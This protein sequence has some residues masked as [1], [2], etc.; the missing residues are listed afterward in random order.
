MEIQGRWVKILPKTFADKKNVEYLQ[1]IIFLFY[2]VPDFKAPMKV[3]FRDLP[4][5]VKIEIIESEITKIGYYVIKV[6]QTVSRK[7]SRVLPFFLLHLPRH[8]NSKNILQQKSLFKIRIELENYMAPRKVAQCWNFQR[9]FHAS[10]QCFMEPQ[11]VACS[12]A[13]KSPVCPRKNLE[14]SETETT[15]QKPP[16]LG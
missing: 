10:A 13:H 12:A 7:D 4:K 16:P 9:F 2:A 6:V 14:T 11:C 3:V 15:I 5:R 1:E 8:K